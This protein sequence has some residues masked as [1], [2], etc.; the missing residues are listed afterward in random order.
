MRP[1]RLP[2]RLAALPLLALAACGSPGPG[3]SFDERDPFRDTN[4]TIHNF[5]VG[6]DRYVLRPISQGYEFVTPEVIQVLLGNAFN[7]IDTINDFANYLFQ[8]E[9]ESAG[10]AL[11]RFTI[12][13]VLGGVGLLDPAT[14]FG[15]P[16]EDTDFDV[17]LGKY[18]VGE[19]AYLVLPLLGPTTTRGIGGFVGDTAVNPL[20]YSGF[21][22]SDVVN[23]FNPAWNA[24]QIVH[25]RAV[26][27][28]L[29]DD[30]F[31]ESENSYISLR[32]IYLQRRDALI[33][34]DEGAD[35]TLPDIFD[36]EP[37]N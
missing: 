19:G 25:E 27:A 31:Y 4:E 16:K 13:T 3:A 14:E 37:T 30:L 28:D 20:T 34:G 10:V 18:G 17:T 21:A 12:N 1:V 22:N 2:L 36:E 9:F 7:H 35:A 24:G 11:G 26:N 29:V 33:L 32:T 5:N 6:A 8:G 23:F 15:L